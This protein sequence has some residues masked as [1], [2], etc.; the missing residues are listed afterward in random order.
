M[1]KIVNQPGV[2]IWWGKGN[3]E[4]ILKNPMT[5]LMVKDVDEKSDWLEL[6][7]AMEESAAGKILTKETRTSGGNLTDTLYRDPND[8]A[9]YAPDELASEYDMTHPFGR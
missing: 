3:R 5:I 9:S 8:L 7:K 1:F 2:L 6:W 4:R